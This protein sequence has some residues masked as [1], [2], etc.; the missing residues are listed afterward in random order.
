MEPE[1]MHEGDI[2]IGVLQKD[3]T[4]GDWQK[5]E[6][7]KPVDLIETYEP[8][9]GEV[10]DTLTEKD[11]TMFYYFVGVVLEEG[12]LIGIDIL[13]AAV[14]YHLKLN[15]E[16]RALFKFMIDA[17]KNEYERKHKFKED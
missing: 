9:V 8:T 1:N 6:G 16:Q 13:R 2:Y 15:K 17:A 7:L 4:V 5:W 10:L 12:E 14:L 3:G 11:R